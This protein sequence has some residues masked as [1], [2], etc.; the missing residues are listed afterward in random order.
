[1]AT[2]KI[3]IIIKTLPALSGIYQF[4]NNRE[5][6]L[7]VG[8]AKNIKKRVSS[9]FTKTHD[10][11]KTLLLIKNIRDVKYIVVETELDALLLENSLIKKYQ[12]K[13]NVKLK[14]DASYPWICIKK[15]E[16]PRIFITRKVIK[17]GSEYYGPYSSVKMA[18]NIL[19]LIRDLYPLRTCNHKLTRE[20]IEKKSFK[21]CLE[22]HI[23]NCNGGCC[24]LETNQDYFENVKIIRD[25]IGG[26]Y[27]IAHKNF[28]LM[29]KDYAKKM[30]FEKA[31]KI[32]EKIHLLETH[33]VKSTIVNPKLKN[34][35]V[36]TIYS[37]SNY[38]YINFIKISN[39]TITYSQNLEIKKQLEE[40]DK[41]LL[42]IGI[43]EMRQ[44]IHSHSRDILV[45]FPINIGDDNVKISVPKLGDKKKV[46][47][48]SYKNARYF[49]QEKLKQT[50][51]V[52]PDRYTNRILEQMKVDLK[53]SERPIHIECFDNSNIQ[54]NS[55]TSACVVFKNAK[56]SKKDYRHFNVKTVLGP[57]DFASM[58]EVIYRRYSR[59]LH[60]D[61]KMPQLIVIDGGKGQV[62]AA[63]KSLKKLD[64]HNS[65]SVIGIAKRLEELFFPNDPIPLYLNKNSDTLKVIQ[66]MRNEAHRFSLRHHRNVRSK[67]A[68]SSELDQI[69]GIGQNSK[70]K[71]LRELKSVSE[72]KN[73]S[74]VEL[75]QILGKVKANRVYTF[76][77]KDYI[78]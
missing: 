24:G 45:P 40:S 21:L 8:K 57:D 61:S 47:D 5:E 2:E 41:E 69:E 71:L 56:P 3:D 30:E 68:I 25:I 46:L 36:Y 9:Y 28:T 15:E 77:N 39:G 10:H 29:M 4:F 62:S 64:I 7:Y 52:D 54:G 22:Y 14:D 32:K 18:K 13:Y 23:D 51:I 58:E 42:E 72:I 48:L 11:K 43:T 75:E 38:A 76:F 34:I 37:D 50:Q 59:L 63:V 70:M 12:P 26:N 20:N 60:E 19:D 6:L 67:R 1:M 49:R 65:V 33:Q 74:L 55:P 66:Q 17:D 16:F 35:D 27:S 78:N 31:Q 44:K 53:L 73:S